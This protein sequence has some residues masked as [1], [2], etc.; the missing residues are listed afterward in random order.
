MVSFTGISPVIQFHCS[1]NV[2]LNQTLPPGM[3]EA[4]VSF[5]NV[6][7]HPISVVGIN[8]LGRGGS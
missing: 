7:R 6:K 2:V 8:I 1:A 5:L 4:C 3:E